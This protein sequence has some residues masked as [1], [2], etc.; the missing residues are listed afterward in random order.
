MPRIDRLVPW[1]LV[2]VAFA[3]GLAVQAQDAGGGVVS[4]ADAP[5]RVAPS[6]KARVRTLTP[7]D[8]SAPAFLGLLELDADARV[9]LHRDE[10]AEYIYVLEGGGAI[11]IDGR[12]YP[13]RPGD[14]ALMPAGAEV[15]FAGGGAPTKALQV[16]AP[17]TSGGKYGGWPVG[18]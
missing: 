16:F 18:E 7:V 15:S 5:V 17:G 6:G 14:A 4:S 10:S 11:T 1:T 2:P 3:A 12:E 13:L 8:P 9:P